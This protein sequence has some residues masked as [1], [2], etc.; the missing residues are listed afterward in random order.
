GLLI[1]HFFEVN[2][3]GYI[4]ILVSAFIIYSGIM[5]IKETSSPLLGEAPSEELVRNIRTIVEAHDAVYGTHDLMV[6]NYGPG[7]IFASIHIEVNADADIL[8]S[9][10][11]IDNIEN[12]VFKKLKIHITG[13]MDPIKINDPIRN[14]ILEALKSKIDE[15]DCVSNIHDLRIVPGPTHTNVI[16]DIVME[17]GCEYTEKEILSWATKIVHKIDLKYFVVINFDKSYL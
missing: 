10:D 17:D 13:H 7:K 5:L 8:E 6:H 4:G 14:E 12:E 11:L 1:S 2:C 9:H 16:F 15:L 3:D